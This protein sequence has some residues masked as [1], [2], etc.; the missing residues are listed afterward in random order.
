MSLIVPK[1]A[2]LKKAESIINYF[3]PLTNW[4]DEQQAYYGYET[5]WELKAWEPVGFTEPPVEAELEGS[6]NTE[7]SS[8]AV[9]AA[10]ALLAT[11]A[12]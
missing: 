10:L 3:K 11:W 12:L 9:T 4:L 7:D 5:E 6:D 2:E 8:Q 1:F